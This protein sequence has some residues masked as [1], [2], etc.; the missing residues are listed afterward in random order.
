VQCW[1]TASLQVVGDGFEPQEFGQKRLCSP[2]LAALH[3]LGQTFGGKGQWGRL[4]RIGHAWPIEH[5]G[6]QAY[7]GSCVERPDRRL[8][9]ASLVYIS[10]VVLLL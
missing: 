3:S 9:H 1:R 4:G 5:C 6:H 10:R 8:V 7:A 2:S